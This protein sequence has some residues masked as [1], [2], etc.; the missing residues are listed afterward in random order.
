VDQPCYHVGMT[1]A[2]AVRYYGTQ[3]KLAAALGVSQPS[4]ANWP[5]RP[6]PYRQIQIEADTG[7]ALKADPGIIPAGSELVTRP[8]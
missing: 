2:E 8:L 1:K 7:G 5:D 6:P 4:I 3:R